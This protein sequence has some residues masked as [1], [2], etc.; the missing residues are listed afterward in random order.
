MERAALVV[1]HLATAVAL[2]GSPSARHSPTWHQHEGNVRTCSQQVLQE[3]LAIWTVTRG[4]RRLSAKS[5]PLRGRILRRTG[6]PFHLQARKQEGLRFQGLISNRFL[7]E[8]TYILGLAFGWCR[9]VGAVLP[10]GESPCSSMS[11]RTGD[12]PWTGCPQNPQKYN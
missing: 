4:K 2:A 5:Q 3:R 9:G 7:G 10:H 1:L 6:V 12:I 8:W 11:R